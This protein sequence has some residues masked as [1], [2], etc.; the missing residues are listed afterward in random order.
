MLRILQKSDIPQAMIIE[1]LTQFTPW[2]EEVFERCYD[3]G[4]RGWVIE[5]GDQLI[6]YLIM[7][8]LAGESHILNVCIHPDFQHQGFGRQLVEAA[9]KNAKEKSDIA[10]LEVRRSNAYAIALYEKMGFIQIS[11]RKNYYPTKEGREDA[12]VFAKDLRV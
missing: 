11:T 4:Y 10:F 7:S 8:T 1:R 6:G 3:A 2:T 9:L 5:Q 12:L